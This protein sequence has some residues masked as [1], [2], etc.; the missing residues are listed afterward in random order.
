MCECKCDKSCGVGEYLGYLNCKHRKGLTD[1]LVFDCEVE[2]FNT[3][4]S[5]VSLQISFN[6]KKVTF[7][8]IIVLFTLFH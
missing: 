4:E 7:K 5:L 2:I 1:R 6:D 8:K 3:T